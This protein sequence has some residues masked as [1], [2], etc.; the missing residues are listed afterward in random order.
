MCDSGSS[1]PARGLD[2]VLLPEDEVAA[3]LPRVEVGVTDLLH[4]FPR[5]LAERVVVVL[6]GLHASPRGVLRLQGLL[7]TDGVLVL[8]SGPH[9]P[10]LHL[11]AVGLPTRR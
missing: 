9:R 5:R 7:V 3:V 2:A 4:L 11:V 6:D 8:L 1:A 10:L